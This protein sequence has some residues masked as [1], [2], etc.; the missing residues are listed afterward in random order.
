MEKKFFEFSNEARIGHNT[1][2]DPNI[3]EN[4]ENNEENEGEMMI[5]TAL[6][7]LERM[8]RVD[9]LEDRPEPGD[10]FDTQ[11]IQHKLKD[12]KKENENCQAR[13]GV[14]NKKN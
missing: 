14:F 3:S 4:N 12:L 9:M 10:M 11:L 13:L 8:E 2:N 5:R 1:S 6:I 7:D